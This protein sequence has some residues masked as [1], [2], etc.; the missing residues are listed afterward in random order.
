MAPISY[1]GVKNRIAYDRGELLSNVVT[2]QNV[3]DRLAE[4]YTGPIGELNKW[5]DGVRAATGESVPYFDPWA[6]SGGAK[7][8]MLLQDPSGA[9]DGESGF[10]SLHNND[11]TAHN[12]YKLCLETSL[13]YADYVPWNVIPWWVANPAKGRRSLGA[14]ARRA[15]RYLEEVVELLPGDLAA[16]IVM[17]KTQTWPAWKAAVG[18]NHRRFHGAEVVFTAHPGPLSINQPD[19]E[20]GRR[21][22]DHLVEVFAHVASMVR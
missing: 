2:P 11:Q 5:V 10:I 9:A 18:P 7:V 13:R 8:L 3:A 12:V 15:R 21:N 22:R 1:R 4:R 14:E 16:V 19:K 20:T 17:G 6:A